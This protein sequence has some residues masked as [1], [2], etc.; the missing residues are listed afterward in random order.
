LLAN[1]FYGSEAPSGETIVLEVERALLEKRGHQISQFFRHSDEI[2]NSGFRGMLTGAMATP[3][4]PFSVRAIRAALDKVLPDIVHVHNTFPLISPSI[5]SAIGSQSA[6]VLTLHNYRLFCPAAIPMRNN[7]VCTECMTKRS[8][9]P[10]LRHGCYRNSKAA[11]VPLAANVALHR[12]LGTWVKHVDAFITLSDFQRDLMVAAG[13]P[14]ELTHVKP[15]FYPGE[16][17]TLPW[18]NR[19]PAVIYAGRLSAEKGV[20]DLL[21]AWIRWGASAP[22]L[23]I[24]GDGEIRSQLES[25]AR[26]NPDIPIRFLGQ[27][28]G[29][30]AHNHIATAQL[31]VLPSRCYEGFPMVIREAFAFGTPVAV[32]DLGPLPTIVSHGENGVVFRAGDPQSLLREVQALW[33][34]P[35]T[36]SALAVGARNTYESKY[37]E[38]VNYQQLMDIYE[39]AKEVS[40]SRK[41]A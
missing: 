18:A 24:L 36:R 34:S 15:N 21:H 9:V 25:I 13:L 6:R 30:E 2:R 22:E 1:N 39:Q 19:E 26:Q 41:R 16:P 23:R 29:E 37:T 4:N 32:S 20:D 27:L 17:D 11:T 31:L 8:V 35:D 12:S 3:W 5:F 33:D 14:A 10:S 7:R 38:E 28:S 40:R